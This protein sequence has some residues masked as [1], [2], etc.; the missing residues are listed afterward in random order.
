VTFC[1]IQI[2][3]AVCEVWIFDQIRDNAHFNRFIFTNARFP[4]ANKPHTKTR[5]RTFTSSRGTNWA[6]DV[7]ASE[8]IL[9]ESDER[10]MIAA[11][12]PRFLQK[13]CL[14]SWQ[15]DSHRLLSRSSIGRFS[16]ESID[17][18]QMCHISRRFSIFIIGHLEKSHASVFA[19]IIEV[20][21]VPCPVAEP[22][23]VIFLLQHIR[24][25]W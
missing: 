15:R 16:D 10:H 24:W 12:L 4:I 21:R 3:T 18:T 1:E 6:T 13:S 7:N 25:I 11:I 9:A 22:L 5:S 14:S 2:L 8:Y 23:T 19:R 17:M 20:I